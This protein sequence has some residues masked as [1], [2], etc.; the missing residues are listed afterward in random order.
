M[1]YRVWE[2]FLKVIIPN[3]SALQG[4]NLNHCTFEF[5]FFIRREHEVEI[6]VYIFLKT[7]I[8]LKVKY[9][10][11]NKDRGCVKETMIQTKS[12]KQKY[13]FQNSVYQLDFQSPTHEHA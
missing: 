5:S 11:D 6:H 8:T 7:D 9:K 4:V 10:I 12:R 1:I 3:W 2:L 13:D